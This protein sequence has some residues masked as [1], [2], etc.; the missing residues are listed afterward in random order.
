MAH[1]LENDL[2]NFDNYYFSSEHDESAI[3]HEYLAFS[4]FWQH[5]IITS[6]YI[7]DTGNFETCNLEMIHSFYENIQRHPIL[8]R[9]FRFIFG[10]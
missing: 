3:F 7:I 8:W 9:F 2:K 6:D 10:V 5:A 4:L 1:N